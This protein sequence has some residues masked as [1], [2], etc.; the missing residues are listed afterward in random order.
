MTGMLSVY[1]LISN[2]LV[3][4]FVPVSMLLGCIVGL[5]GLISIYPAYVI[6]VP[7]YL[8]LFYDIT[9]AKIISHFP[10]SQVRIPQL[11]VYIL[12]FFYTA[13]FFY[14]LYKKKSFKG[15]S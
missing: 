11:V 6:A 14:F 5:V 13:G 2:I 1:G 4:P 10:F 7:T 8:V 9:I 12:L 15:T 3:L